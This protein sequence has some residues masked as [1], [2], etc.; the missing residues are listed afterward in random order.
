ME[1]SIPPF[2][3][4]MERGYIESKRGASE[5]VLPCFIGEAMVC[6]FAICFDGLL[7][8]SVDCFRILVPGRLVGRVRRLFVRC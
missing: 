5:G 1:W 7:G 6:I 8:G 3:D 2:Y 4:D